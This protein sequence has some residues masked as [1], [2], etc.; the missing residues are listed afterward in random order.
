MG[1]QGCHQHNLLIIMLTCK[2]LF[3]DM[4]QMTQSPSWKI[5]TCPYNLYLLQFHLFDTYDNLTPIE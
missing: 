5:I 2:T 1:E 3:Y 4:F